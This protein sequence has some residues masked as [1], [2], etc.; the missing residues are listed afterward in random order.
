L[1]AEARA[2]RIP[3][4]LV[5][6][7]LSPRSESRFNRFRAFVVPTFRLLDLVCVPEPNDVGRWQAL[8]IKRNRI[9]HTGSIKYDSSA[10]A[11]P[12]GGRHR[13]VGSDAVDSTRPVLFGGSTHSGEERLLAEVFLR[14]RDR[15]PSLCLF[16]APRHVER[17]REIRTQLENL[18]LKVRFTSEIQLQS[19]SQPD[20]ILLDRTGELRLW[21]RIA[22][23]AFIGKSLTAHGGQN[24]VEPIRAGV[25]V[26]FGP[27]ME[28]FARLASALVAN[29]GA[30]QVA[31]ENAL[32]EAVDK[33]L[34]DE[35]AR[36]AL[37]RNAEEVLTSHAGATARTAAL[38]SALPV[39]P[40]DRGA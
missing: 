24:P 27:H 36:R 13:T 17:V 35:S 11:A 34:R 40:I 12:D 23:I 3:V 9:H 19:N 29:N 4:A 18:S 7:R 37:V 1:L 26:I 31:D 15:L 10:V 28:N 25:P 32:E 6:A 39:K 21:Y 30:I 16:I 2:R 38:V 20:C 8:G 14:L 33:L 5:S 22:S